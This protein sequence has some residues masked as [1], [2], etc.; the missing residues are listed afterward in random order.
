MSFARSVF[1]F[2]LVA[3]STLSCASLACAQA[4][5]QP[6]AYFWEPPKTPGPILAKFCPIA[7][8]VVI[9]E[10]AT[11]AALAVGGDTYTDAYLP[12]GLSPFST[13]NGFSVKKLR[14][15]YVSKGWLSLNSSGQDQELCIFLQNVKTAAHEPSSLLGSDEFDPAD[16]RTREK[17]DVDADSDVGPDRLFNPSEP[18]SLPSEVL[19]QFRRR[20]P[21]ML[22]GREKA[23]QFWSTFASSLTSANVTANRLHL[24][25][26]PLARSGEGFVY[27]APAIDPYFYHYTYIDLALTDAFSPHD[28]FLLYALPLENQGHKPVLV[29]GEW[30]L[31]P[32]ASTFPTSANRWNNVLVPGFG[33]NTM[34]SL[35]NQVKGSFNNRDNPLMA[36]GSSI[37]YFPQSPTVL[38]FGPATSTDARA[39]HAT[40]IWYAQICQRALAAAHTQTAV[41][42]M[43]SS[44][45]NLKGSNYEMMT[46][47]PGVQD[48]GWHQ[49]VPAGASGTPQPFVR[50]G[51]RGYKDSGNHGS[52]IA[53]LSQGPDYDWIN[54]HELERVGDF[55][56]PPLYAVGMNRASATPGQPIEGWLDYRQNDA[57]LPGYPLDDRWTASMR[58]HRWTLES[59]IASEGVRNGMPTNGPKPWETIAPWIVPPGI[60]GVIFIDKLGPDESNSN[61]YVPTPD[62]INRQLG[63]LRSKAIPELLVFNPRSVNDSGQIITSASDG[64]ADFT[65]VYKQVYEPYL[66]KVENVTYA[67]E[68]PP[69]PTPAQKIERV[70]DTNPRF[71]GSSA[72]YTAQPHRWH[73]RRV[74]NAPTPAQ[75]N[76]DVPSLISVEA[77]VAP[78]RAQLA[79]DEMLRITIEVEAELAVPSAVGAWGNP[80]VYALIEWTSWQPGSNNTEIPVPHFLEVWDGEVTN[81]TGPTTLLSPTY[82]GFHAPRQSITPPA[83]SDAAWRWEMRRTF[84]I[85]LP[86]NCPTQFVKSDGTVHFRLWVIAKHRDPVTNQFVDNPQFPAGVTLDVKHDLIQVVRAPEIDIECGP[87]GGQQAMSMLTLGDPV[88]ADINA[89]GHED[90]T[91]LALFLHALS[92]GQP[93]ADVNFDEQIDGDDVEQ[94]MTDYTDP[95]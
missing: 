23:T 31:E 70:A 9:D 38:A 56:S 92:E 59:I 13:P 82:I 72:P 25:I 73:L 85:G 90:T 37:N 14:D 8:V 78:S 36:T 18:D 49:P 34:A 86:S 61:V 16:E 2:G 44:F 26:E 75:P 19:Q 88:G 42:S 94:F 93:L 67:P 87:S 32:T 63:L 1:V 69:V 20:Q 30:Q 47:S 76:Q 48:F 24:D 79:V 10:N 68:V 22:A 45:P 41:N 95:Q 51:E 89:S 40:Y 3:G 53:T 71:S 62:D 64:Y 33:T 29:D 57:Y 11:A 52:N 91:D 58:W 35:W 66:T 60:N 17:I 74:T 5:L 54:Y 81:P 27:V 83:G 6:Q 50:L 65:K 80:S 4:S 28:A 21:W 46:M 39:N 77:K 15:Y 43:K 55:S 7:R 84:D 12:L